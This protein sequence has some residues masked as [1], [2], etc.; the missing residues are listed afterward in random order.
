VVP[1]PVRG[2]FG[3][4]HGSAGS[5]GDHVRCC[6]CSAGDHVDALRGEPLGLAFEIR[7]DQQ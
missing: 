6:A 1:D 3:N 2:L 5:T 7:Q 4:V